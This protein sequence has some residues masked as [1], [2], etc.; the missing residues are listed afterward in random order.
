MI[1]KERKIPL[2]I[3][4]LQAL[5]RRLPPAPPKIP[6]IMSELSKKE[7]GYRGECAIDFPLSFLET[8]EYFIFHDIRLQDQTRFFQIDTLLLS[9]KFILIIEVKN[10]AGSLY[11]DSTFNQLIRTK[12]GKEM[13]FPDPLNQIERH[14][15]Q[16]KSWLMK[17]GL[18]EPP[19]YSLVVISNPQTIIRANPENRNLHYKVIHRDT[20]PFKIHQIEKSIN[21]PSLSDKELKKIIK[22][23]NKHHTEADASVLERFNLSMEDFIKGVICEKCLMSPLLRQRREWRCSRCE[24][25]SKDGHIRALKDYYFLL[26]PTITNRQLR[27]FLSISSSASATRILRSMNLVSE[28]MNKGKVY[29]VPFEYEKEADS[30]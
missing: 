24:H 9:R 17:H 22:I 15:S 13:G 2:S 19:I 18:T 6:F 23:I 1:I 10:I 16:L 5:L 20:L 29:R 14:E 3:L 7:A 12:D 26:G 27:E 21:Q 25:E 28:G 8:K 11:F 30:N 4:K